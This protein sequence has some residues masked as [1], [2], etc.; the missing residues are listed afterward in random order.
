MGLS[1]PLTNLAW[2]AANAALGTALLR[3]YDGSRGERAAL[4]A[5]A[6]G[7]AVALTAYFGRLDLRV[8]QTG[9]RGSGR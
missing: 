5:S 8:P 6:A 1:G 4:A 2:S 9:R 7:T 3:G